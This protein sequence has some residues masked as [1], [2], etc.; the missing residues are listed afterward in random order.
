[1]PEPPKPARIEPVRAVDGRAM[2][3][4]SAMLLAAIVTLILLAG[5]FGREATIRQQPS[6]HW[7]RLSDH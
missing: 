5:R 1:M 7:T 3:L 4:V 6:G 2:L